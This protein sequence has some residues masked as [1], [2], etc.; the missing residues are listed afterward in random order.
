MLRRGTASGNL[1]ESEKEA[2]KKEATREYFER[3]RQSTREKQRQAFQPNPARRQ[4]IL[5][6]ARRK[7]IAAMPEGSLE[8]NIAEQKIQVKDAHARLASENPVATREQIEAENREASSS[9]GGIGGLTKK[10]TAAMAA[11]ATVDK[12]IP[13][14]ITQTI[15]VQDINSVTEND[16][17]IKQLNER[18][19]Q[20]SKDIKK[21][22]DDLTEFKSQLT[23]LK[24]ELSN[25]ECGIGKKCFTNEADVTPKNVRAKL[26]KAY[27][28]IGDNNKVL[29]ELL[30]SQCGN[31]PCFNEKETLISQY[32]YES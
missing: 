9:S 29:K 10:I 28:E 12:A 25:A 1:S 19:S 24:T 2:R 7:R 26:T 15:S 5:A 6:N 18:N 30:N 21:N 31:I 13:E 32:I 23:E 14:T 8:R 4:A 22:I 17:N 11:V 16:E 20:I 3:L 27:T